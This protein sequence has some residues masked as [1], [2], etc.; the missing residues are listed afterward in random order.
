MSE[1]ITRYGYF[2]EDPEGQDTGAYIDDCEDGE[3]VLWI[4]HVRAVAEAYKRGQEAMRKAANR[5]AMDCIGR[6]EC[7]R[8]IADGIRSIP[9]REEGA[10]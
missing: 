4:D 10:T 7:P 8:A 9:I 6:D 2:E 5:Y 1:P 3:Y